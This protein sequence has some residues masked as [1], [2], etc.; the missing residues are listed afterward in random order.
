[1]LSAEPL[2]STIGIL[3]LSAIGAAVPVGEEP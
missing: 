2:A 3:Y 1:M